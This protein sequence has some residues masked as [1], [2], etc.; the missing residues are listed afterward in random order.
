M[1]N[2][3]ALT[4]ETLYEDNKRELSL[5][6][7]N[8]AAGL[9]K[10][11]L[12]PDLCRPGLLLS[13]FTKTFAEKK[14]QVFG[15]TE[16]SFL[17]NLEKSRRLEAFSRLIQFNIPC[18]VVANGGVIDD[19]LLST[20]GQAAVCVMQ[21]PSPTIH[22]YQTLFDY[23]NEKSAP[24]TNVHGTLV[25]VYGVG[26]LFTGKSGIGKSEIALDLLERG[27]RLVADDVVAIIRKRPGVLIG[28]SREILKSML[29]IRGVGLIDAWSI[30]G[31]R[32]IRVQKRVEV[33]V[34]LEHAKDIA[35]YDRIGADVKYKTYLGVKIPQHRLPIFPGKNITVIAEVIALKVM[36]RVYGIQPEQDF[37]R[38]LDD[39]IKEN[40]KIREYLWGDHE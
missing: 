27:H 33:E 17:E 1:K 4:V 34:K 20:A 13:G 35:Q 7:L 15:D 26:V 19:R 3:G 8:G 21:S 31:I 16:L 12:E 36:Q 25:D 30:F 23:L 22:I 6:L 14:I 18:L 2:T 9:H 5:K 40:T 29:E 10:E 38:R 39:R 28:T 32:G 24:R 11:I 37:L